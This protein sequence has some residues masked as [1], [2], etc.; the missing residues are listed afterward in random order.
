[1]SRIRALNMK[2]QQ[3]AETV[4]R[5]VRGYTFS[6][7]CTSFAPGWEVGTNDQ[8]DPCPWKSDLALCWSTC[9]WMG[10]VPDYLAH[11]NWLDSCGNTNV[12]WRNLCTVPDN[13]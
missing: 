4:S 12:D 6:D 9:Y 5:D 10:Q 7:C 13:G 8:P 11:A 1:M 2:A 3:V